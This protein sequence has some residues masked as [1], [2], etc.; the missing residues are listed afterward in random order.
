[1]QLVVLVG[2]QA[3]G[4][5]TFYRER[6]A[7]THA[8]VSLDL[9][10]TRHREAARFREHLEAG[11]KIVI[12]NTSPTP[13]DRARFVPPALERGYEAHAYFFQTEL[14][15]ALA[16]NRLREGKAR[17]PDMAVL[18]THK[19]L[20]A[21]AREEGFAKLFVVRLVP[22]RGFVVTSTRTIARSRPAQ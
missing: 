15:D 17:V 6:F 8:H 19:K 1:M 13:L 9:L 16:R 3:S 7:A 2:V 21:P 4:K 11:M 18:G 5:S 12:D 20:V 22:D 14:E 10:E